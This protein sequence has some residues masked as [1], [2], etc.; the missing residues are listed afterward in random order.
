[1][2]VP[3]SGDLFEKNGI[4]FVKLTLSCKI[5]TEYRFA[6]IW[7]LTHFCISLEVRVTPN[8]KLCLVIDPDAN[9]SCN[10]QLK[11][12][13]L[14]GQLITLML[15]SLRRGLPKSLLRNIWCLGKIYL[16]LCSALK[17]KPVHNFAESN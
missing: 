4:C 6:N 9:V 10:R 5:L 17:G 1:M 3:L 14:A 15:Y 11:L 16:N 2:I 13:S 7:H 12:Q 8:K